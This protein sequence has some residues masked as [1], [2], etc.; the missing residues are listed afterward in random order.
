MQLQKSRIKAN[1]DSIVASGYCGMREYIRNNLSSHFRETLLG[2]IL[3]RLLDVNALRG[4]GSS[5][6]GTLPFV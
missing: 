1:L 3:A 2:Q 6:S 5:E 4:T